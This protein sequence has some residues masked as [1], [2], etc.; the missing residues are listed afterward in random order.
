MDDTQIRYKRAEKRFHVRGRL[1]FWS[2]GQTQ[3]VTE[4]FNR[5]DARITPGMSHGHQSAGTIVAC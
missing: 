3:R 4:L 2:H 5:H 1:P